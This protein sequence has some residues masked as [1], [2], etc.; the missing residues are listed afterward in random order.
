M[1]SYKHIAKIMALAI[2]VLFIMVVTTNGYAGIGSDIKNGTKKVYHK[3][4]K[5]VK[6]VT[7]KGKKYVKK[8]NKIFHKGK[9]VGKSLGRGYARVGNTLYKVVKNQAKA[10]GEGCIIIGK[11]I[12]RVQQNVL[13][14]YV[15]VGGEIFENGML[16]GRIAGKGLIY[17][18]ETEYKIVKGTA[19]TVGAGYIKIGN[20]VYKQVGKAGAGVAGAA[21]GAGAHRHAKPD[22][23]I[24]KIYLDRNCNVIVR[25]K[26]A[27]KG[28]VPKTVWTKHY[29]KSSSVY[30]KVNGKGWGGATIWKLDPRRRLQKPG[31]TAI[32]KSN[33]KVAKSARITAT[34]DHTKQVAESNERNNRK[35]LR[36]KCKKRP[37]AEDRE[38]SDVRTERRVRPE[39]SPIPGTVVKPG[40]IVRLAKPDLVID[41]VYLNRNCN[42]VVRVKNNGKGSIADSVWT[43]HYPKSSSVYLKV[44]GKGWGGATIWKFDPRRRLQKPG[45]VAIYKSNLKV[46]KSARITATIDHTKQVAESNERNNR[47]T[48]SL[49]CKKRPVTEGKVRPEVSP[50]PGAVVKPGKIVRLAKPDLLVDKISLDTNCNVVVKIRNSGKGKLPNSVWT[51]K[52][53]K[54][55]GVYLY[56]NGKKWGGATIWK[57]DPRRR[58]QKSGGT[59][60]YKSN[61]KVN[62]KANIKAVIDMWN[63]V[64]ESQ[65]GNN[66]KITTLACLKAAGKISV[67]TI[68]TVKSPTRTETLPEGAIGISGQAQIKT[69]I[70]EIPVKPNQLNPREPVELQQKY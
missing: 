59:A 31:G 50:I 34:I 25:V 70:P 17:I 33:L 37:V 9:N 27:G 67:K 43:R 62:G 51:N 26:N 15:A 65:E 14:G 60:I 39:V 49:K 36:L 23:K 35:T 22:L 63:Q 24:D 28:R 57:F 53:P 61:L 68:R 41:R 47:K 11:T 21:T 10:T 29:P 7:H 52:N 66:A 3:G 1:K 16:V 32:Y 30:L 18:G 46:A 6:K 2:A 44:N 20:T 69:G 38:A 54:S 42:V 55:A 64:A 4:K 12:Y 5:A 58:L 13:R 8:G 48:R 45:G 40:K 19:R 56:I